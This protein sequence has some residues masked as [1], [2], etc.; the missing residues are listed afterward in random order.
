MVTVF[1]NINNINLVFHIFDL[2]H[3]IIKNYLCDL[4]V[5]NFREKVKFKFKI[6]QYIK[7]RI[8]FNTLKN[9]RLPTFFF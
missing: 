9:T 2:I 8:H 1:V 5:L 7:D 3:F 4:P 6:A